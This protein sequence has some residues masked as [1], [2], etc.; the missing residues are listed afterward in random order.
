M[1][2]IKIKKIID[3]VDFKIIKILNRRDLSINKK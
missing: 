1:S 2:K 3:V